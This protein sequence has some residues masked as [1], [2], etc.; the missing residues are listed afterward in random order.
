MNRL[1]EE[2]E[3]HE[4]GGSGSRREVVGEEGKRD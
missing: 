1:E 2:R 3:V 4:G